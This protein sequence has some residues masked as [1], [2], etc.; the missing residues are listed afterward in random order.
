MLFSSRRVLFFVA[1]LGFVL[2]AA[3]VLTSHPAA[4]WRLDVVYA[5][6]TG[7]WPG[8]PWPELLPQLL[9]T[10]AE[11]N[12]GHWVLGNAVLTR[13][14]PDGPC[15]ATFAA[16]F[17]EF[18]GLVAD[19][20]DIEHQVNKYLGL[21]S[22]TEF[23]LIPAVRPGDVV[24]E[25]GPW[26]GSF[27]R[28][29]LARGAQ[30]V[31]AIEPAPANIAC[32][33]MNFKEEIAAGRV[34]LVK[35]AAW[36]ESGRVRITRDGPTASH[37]S[38]EGYAVDPNGELEVRAL[39]LDDALTELGV[40]HVDLINLDIEGAERHALAGAKRTIR[41]DRPEIVVCVHH[42]P[43]DEDAITTV[44]EQIAPEYEV[45]TDGYHARYLRQPR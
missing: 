13:V 14:E 36:S 15:P 31:I 20:F 42:L 19:E 12:G 40:E 3:L 16:P 11:T 26:I 33:E 34:V 4:R 23:G 10:T 6:L 1:A 22:G 45:L 30:T 35:A 25:L 32:F 37:G 9:G 21:E 44:M 38:N 7:Q 24:V 39:T 28:Y 29:A 43:D 18:R 17:G 2:A 41:R 8:M 5:K 27:T